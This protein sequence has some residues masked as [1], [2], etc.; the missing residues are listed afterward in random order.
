MAPWNAPATIA[1]HRSLNPKERFGGSCCIESRRR[2][3]EAAD[4]KR[5][6]DWPPSV[7]GKAE[8]ARENRDENVNLS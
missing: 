4:G 6:S 3:K 7:F 1:L 2:G 5:E 8:V